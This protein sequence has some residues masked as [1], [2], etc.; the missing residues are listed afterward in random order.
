MGSVKNKSTV[1]VDNEYDSDLF[2]SYD[3]WIPA[4]TGRWSRLFRLCSSHHYGMVDFDTH[5]YLQEQK[6]SLLCQKIIA[7]TYT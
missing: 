3:Q 5:Q 1:H 6:W 7:A 2:H 4:H